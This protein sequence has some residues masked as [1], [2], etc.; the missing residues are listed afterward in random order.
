MNMPLNLRSK[1]ID[2]LNK[3]KHT[4]L[5]VYKTLNKANTLNVLFLV[6]V[7]LTLPV[8]AR[9]QDKIITVRTEAIDERDLDN[10]LVKYFNN[11]SEIARDNSENAQANLNI[12]TLNISIIPSGMT[13]EYL[14]ENAGPNPT[15]GPTSVRASN[16]QEN[17]YI[18]LSN[19]LGQEKGSVELDKGAG[20]YL[21]GFGGLDKQGKPLSDGIYFVTMVTHDGKKTI[22]KTAK[23]LVLNNR[24]GYNGL[25]ASLEI[26]YQEMNV[27]KVADLRDMDYITFEGE[28]IST[29]SLYLETPNSSVS[30]TKQLNIK[31]TITS[32]INEQYIEEGE[33][34]EVNVNQHVDNDQQSVYEV[35]NDAF[36]V[37]DSI[38]SIEAV[39]AGTY[40]TMIRVIDAIDPSFTDSL[41]YR[42]L[43]DLAEHAPTA[44]IEG[45]VASS[46][47]LVTAPQTMNLGTV[48]V[49]DQDPENTHTMEIIGQTQAGNANVYLN[50]NQLMMSVLNDYFNGNVNFG[51]KVTDNTGL[52]DTLNLTHYVT[53]QP[54]ITLKLRDLTREGMPVFTDMTSTIQ[55][56]DSLYQVSDGE[57]TRQLVA[58]E[59]YEIWGENDSTGVFQEGTKLFDDWIAIRTQGMQWLEEENLAQRSYQ[60]YTSEITFTGEDMT[61]ELY[62]LGKTTLEDFQKLKIIIDSHGPP[63]IDRPNTLTPELWVDTSYVDFAMP[64]SQTYED[65]R[66][67]IEVLLPE[68][69]SEFGFAPQWMGYGTPTPYDPEGIEPTVY[70]KIFDESI[71]PPGWSAYSANPDNTIYSASTLFPTTNIMLGAAV[72]S[73][74]AYLGMIGDPG[75]D[76]GITD[77]IVESVNEQGVPQFNDFFYSVLR[78]WFVFDKGSNI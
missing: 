56:G 6:L 2:N 60:D 7:T 26:P 16:L 36:T 76:G 66:Y 9:A 29:D 70:K 55:I 10:I 57:I 48:R 77:D 43:V 27:G 38:V 1:F 68:L 64:D 62:K 52:S 32:Q 15:Y 13:I 30:L 63:G 28:N 5:P 17:G 42:V 11:N 39:T 65:A 35:S 4:A 23:F 69:C 67:V 44:S 46:D 12:G 19:I 47:E 78:T 51:V 34:T 53:A 45:Y 58:G 54:D 61:L 14:I 24:S 49:T 21:I 50:E 72:E 59:S 18:R 8:A 75:D 3:A 73:I 74:Q 31:P 40:E 71:N 22:T 41:L 33:F 37:S 25:V 20:Q